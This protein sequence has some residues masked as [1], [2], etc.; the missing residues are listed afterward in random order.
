MTTT[1]ARTGTSIA[2]IADGLFRIS[3][4]VPPEAIPG[5]LTFNQFLLV[6]DAPLL[7]HTGP[8]K[9]FPAIRDAVRGVL[10]L[11]KLRWISFSHF[12][13][14]ECG[15]LNEWLAAAPASQ[16]LCSQLAALVS[17]ADVADREPRGLADGETLSLG[18]RTV[19]WLDAPHLPHGM[20]CGYLFD[21]TDRVLLCGDLFS[22]PGVDMPAL[23]ESAMA[24]WEPSEVMR[25]GFPY[26]P[27][28]GADAVVERLARADP[29]LLAC[30]HGSS[31][32][33]DGAALLRQLGN[34]LAA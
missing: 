12:E 32:R 3:T 18:R 9:L 5:G 1:D 11:E 22:Q 8:R 2:E 7:F 28:R 14:D 24:I 6:D 4:P 29:R 23:T 17:V 21:E 15:S 10:P 27:I 31:F 19:R 34:A 20:E 16:P 13:A 33:G 25:R 26:A 30:M